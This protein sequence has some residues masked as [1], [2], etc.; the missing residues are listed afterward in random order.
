MSKNTCVR[1]YFLVLN[2]LQ[3]IA[4]F[5]NESD[6]VM[7]AQAEKEEDKFVVREL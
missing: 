2:M 4:D 6:Q 7:V 5:Y 3:V 1:N